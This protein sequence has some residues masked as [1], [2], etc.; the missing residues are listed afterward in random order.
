MVSNILLVGIGGAG[1]SI[2]RYLAQR[3]A[4][5]STFP[6]G[7]FAVNILGCLLIGLFAG[8]ATKNLL[9]ESHKFLLMTGFCGGFTTFSAFSIE[10]LN[11]LEE[12]RW[13]T[14]AMY[15]SLSVGLGIAATLAGYKLSS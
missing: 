8:L 10:A 12:N 1:G 7:T 9:T 11:M 5:E 15:V 13:L 6:Y 2:L 14:F 3:W 4:N